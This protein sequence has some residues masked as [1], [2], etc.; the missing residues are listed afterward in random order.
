[1]CDRHL[2]RRMDI[3]ARDR[4]PDQVTEGCAL[5]VACKASAD[6]NDWQSAFSTRS[7]DDR[8]LAGSCRE[9]ILSHAAGVLGAGSGAPVQVQP[10]HESKR[11][12]EKHVAGIRVDNE[13]LE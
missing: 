2:Y 9:A 3:L 6:G 13:A 12:P 4:A 10:N 7:N 8:L 5:S 11:K 1:L